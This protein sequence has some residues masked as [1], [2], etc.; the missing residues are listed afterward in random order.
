MGKIDNIQGVWVYRLNKRKR[1]GFLR[2][3]LRQWRFTQYLLLPL[4]KNL[5]HTVVIFKI[6]LIAEN[7]S[8]RGESISVEILSCSRQNVERRWASLIHVSII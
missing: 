8:K 1:K 2:D 4:T 5:L 3:K 7:N 6:Y